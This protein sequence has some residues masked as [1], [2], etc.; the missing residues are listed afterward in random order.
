MSRKHNIAISFVMNW[1]GCSDN[2]TKMTRIL[3]ARTP[4]LGE[5]MSRKMHWAALA[6]LAATI[7]ALSSMAG[8]AA[9]PIIP[10]MSISVAPKVLSVA[11]GASVEVS[12]RAQGGEAMRLFVDWS[13]QE[14]AAGG[15]VTPLAEA[16][17]GTSSATYTAPAH[18]SGPVHIMASVRGHPQ[19]RACVTVGS[20][21]ATQNAPVD[22]DGCVPAP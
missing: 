20:G 15:T 3:T 10:K 4:S 6:R 7:L 9:K 17:D 2:L 22:K 13:I 14:G 1:Q 19:L 8:V 16:A 21:A 18:A 5:K 11:P 12:A